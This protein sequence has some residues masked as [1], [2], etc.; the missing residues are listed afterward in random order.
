MKPSNTHAVSPVI[1][2]M[3]MIV[4]VIIIAAVVS[5]F[6]G[7]LAGSPT[8]KAPSLILDVKIINTG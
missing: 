4:V 7:G 2:V 8:K 3:L 1:G 6:A 5:A